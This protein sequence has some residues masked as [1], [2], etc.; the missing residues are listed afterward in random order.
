MG[1]SKM[2]IPEPV[3]KIMMML[4]ESAQENLMEMVMQRPHSLNILMIPCSLALAYLPHFIRYGIIYQTCPSEIL[5][6][7]TEP[8]KAGVQ[9]AEAGGEQSAALARRL[10]AAHYNGLEVFPG[11]AAAIL[12]A[13]AM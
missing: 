2:S 10:S 9:R 12:A 3:M 5:Q 4:P 13:V 8:R 11:F 1:S 6:D 7:N